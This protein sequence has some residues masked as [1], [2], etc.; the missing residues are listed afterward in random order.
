MRL[1]LLAL[2]LF[3]TLPAHAQTERAQ[4][5]N[6][7][8][9]ATDYADGRWHGGAGS[10]RRELAP[11]SE[12][13]LLVLDGGS[14]EAYASTE[15]V[16]QRGRRAGP[17]DGEPSD[18]SAS[19]SYRVRIEPEA[20]RV[21]VEGLLRRATAADV[22][23]WGNP[24]FDPWT[25]MA[26]ELV[27]QTIEETPEGLRF[28]YTAEVVSLPDSANA[29]QPVLDGDRL[30]AWGWNLFP[31]PVTGRA[32]EAI[33]LSFELPAGWRFATSYGSSPEVHLE[34]LADLRGLPIAAGAF[35]VRAREAAGRRVQVAVRAG[36]P[37]S[38]DQ[39][40]DGVQALVEAGIRLAGASLPERVFAGIDVG[41]G[42]SLP[43]WAAAGRPQ[44]QASF[45]VANGAGPEGDPGLWGTLGHELAHSWQLAFHISSYVGMG[46][47]FAEGLTNYL[48]YRFA[49]EAGLYS[50]Q[51]LAEAFTRDLREYREIRAL[52]EDAWLRGTLGY[53]EGTLRGLV[54]DVELLRATD[55]RAG[56]DDLYRL[57][58]ERHVGRTL[59]HEL[60]REALVELGGDR[61]GGVYDEVRTASPVEIAPYLE[62]TGIHVVTTGGEEEVRFEPASGSE[63]EFLRRFLSPLSPA[64]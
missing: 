53:S 25:F 15:R 18:P 11:G 4:P 62:G 20:Q 58:L 39:I 10:V 40:A 59:T 44:H 14:T 22:T 56:F 43:L 45:W 26:P 63:A 47:W 21:H 3:A 32:V 17:A 60:V 49:H 33:S 27:P 28:A 64:D 57:L 6:P 2:V 24:R 41:G 5:P 1:L 7:D 48:G 30:R 34:T 9:L 16:R 35:H 38:P 29:V 31:T 13:S 61:L 52:P 51:Q 23:S 42:P 12:A 54:L 50:D 55:G 46:Q 36:H 19:L 37:A 8:A